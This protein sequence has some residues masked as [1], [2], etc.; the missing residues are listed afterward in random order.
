MNGECNACVARCPA[1]AIT[2]NGHDK[3]KCL[4]YI[5]PKLQYLLKK[6]DVGIV[7][8]GLCQTK[9]PCESCNPAK[10]LNN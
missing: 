4:E 2:E 7:G 8:C 5:D 1:G 6:Y 9:V 3:A 10:S